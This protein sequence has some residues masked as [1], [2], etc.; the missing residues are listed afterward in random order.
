MSDT[1]WERLGCLAFAFVLALL[2]TF[3]VGLFCDQL[4]I[5]FRFV[6]FLLTHGVCLAGAGWCA[7]AVLDEGIK[8]FLFIYFL[9]VTIC[10]LLA[11]TAWW[12]T[13]VP[14][15]PFLWWFG[16]F[17]FFIATAG[18]GATIFGVL[19][20]GD[21]LGFV[22][23][24]L[25]GALTVSFLVFYLKLAPPPGH[26]LDTHS[27]LATWPWWKVLIVI[28]LGKGVGL[29]VRMLKGG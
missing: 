29:G 5:G 22:V 2:L 9:I 27:P 17:Y 6:G 14:R 19:E 13:P 11:W 8:V 21:P 12:T 24:P 28:I 7:H 18:A 25:V 16:L 1:V 15:A 20:H 4:P 23:A 3:M 10:A 26:M